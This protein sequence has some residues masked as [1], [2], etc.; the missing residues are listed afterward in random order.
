MMR[1]N[2][3]KPRFVADGATRLRRSP[4]YQARLRQ[5]RESIRERHAKELAQAH[6]FRR[7]G[8]HLRIAAEFRRARRQIEPSSH[9]LFNSQPCR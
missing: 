4:E 8:L 5:L 7:L 9:A 3:T 6:F 1:E 2:T